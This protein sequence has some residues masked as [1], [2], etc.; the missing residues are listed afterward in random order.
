MK[1]L[2]YNSWNDELT[3]ADQ[4]DRRLIWAVVAVM[5]IAAGAALALLR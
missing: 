5:L 4:F 2:D 3:K 1:K